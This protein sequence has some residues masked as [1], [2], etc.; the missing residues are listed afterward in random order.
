V[1]FDRPR[2]HLLLSLP[3]HK[4]DGVRMNL[5]APASRLDD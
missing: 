4:L 2:S 3:G 1:Q 5:N